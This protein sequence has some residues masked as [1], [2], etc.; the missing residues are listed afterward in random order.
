[1][2]IELLNVFV[3]MMLAEEARGVVMKP[4]LSALISWKIIVV[5]H[6]QLPVALHHWV[7]VTVK[8]LG[9]VENEQGMGVKELEQVVLAV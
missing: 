9:P 1:M 3:V 4:E 6:G 5:P 7:T 8:L 2:T